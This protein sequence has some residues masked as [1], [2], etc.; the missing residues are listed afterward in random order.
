MFGTWTNAKSFGLFSRSLAAASGGRTRFFGGGFGLVG[1]LTG[2]ATAT[3]LN[4][5]ADGLHALCQ[6]SDNRQDTRQVVWR[7]TGRATEILME[8]AKQ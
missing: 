8:K 5:A 2:M 1:A 6:T 4:V 7:I 3:V